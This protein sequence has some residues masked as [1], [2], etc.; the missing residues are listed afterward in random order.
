MVANRDYVYAVNLRVHD[1]HSPDHIP[2]QPSQ[3]QFDQGASDRRPGR[4]SLAGQMPTAPHPMNDSVFMFMSMF[5]SM[6]GG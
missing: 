2:D 1:E 5:M 6:P 4:T 3:Q